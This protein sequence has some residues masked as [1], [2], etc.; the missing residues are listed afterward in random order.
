MIANEET[1]W[2]NVGHF[3]VRLAVALVVVGVGLVALSFLSGRIGSN[4]NRDRKHAPDGRE[5][6]GLAIAGAG[7]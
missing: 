7:L 5:G 6:T 3:P 4:Q 1:R 2:P